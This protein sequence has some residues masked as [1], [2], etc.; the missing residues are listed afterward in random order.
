VLVAALLWQ[1]A[2]PPRSSYA[3][4]G[5]DGL[6]GWESDDPAAALPALLASCRVLS[7]RRD[8]E[9]FGGGSAGD[10]GRVADWR[11]PCA[12]AAALSAHDAT[13]VRRFFEARFTPFA[14]ADRGDTDGLFTGYFEIELNGSRRR[15]GVYQTPIYR[16]P[17]DLAAG[18]SYTRAQIE[19]G[20]LA[21]RGLELL[22]LDDPIDAFFLEIQG[23]GRV[24]LD[25]GTT[26]RVGYEGKNG[27]PYVAIGRLL[28]E[29]GAV[30]R[31]RLTMASLRDWMQR[32]PAEGAALR[33]ENSSYVF[34]REI[35]GDGPIGSQGVA[36]TAGRSLAVD[37]Q[38]VPLG[39]PL[40]LVAE[41]RY[42]QDEKLRRLV[43]A[44]DTGGAIRGPVRGD[45]FW[46]SGEEAG[47]RA[48]A[49]NARGHY[50]LLLPKGVLPP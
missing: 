44:Q 38:F 19:D 18:P 16:R 37:P 8:E 7:T 23:S 49:M 20:A 21:G 9:F 45:L 5:F 27:Q 43:V 10:F 3:P 42:R 33:R 35:A 25:D 17:P 15:H 1:C 13:A 31:E 24:R 41:E 11:E 6:E 14:V 50:Y 40:W 30:P 12:E 34:F 22:W 32:H 47:A 36:L 28:V 4:V 26:I 39:A 48:G 2:A 46:G 29:R